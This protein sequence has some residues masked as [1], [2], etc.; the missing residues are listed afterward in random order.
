MVPGEPDGWRVVAELKRDALGRVERVVHAD[1]RVGV[2]RVACGGSLPGSRLVARVLLRRERRAL[3]ALAGLPQVPTLLAHGRGW[4]VR[5][6]F[7][8]EPLHR[9][10]ALPRDFFAHLGDLVARLHARGVAHNDLHKEPNVL[11]LA[12]G[13]PALVDFQL[14]SVHRPGSRGLRTRSAEDRRHVH[15]HAT[16]YERQ[17]M[18]AAAEEVERSFAARVWARGWKPFYNTLTRRWLRRPDAEG[19]RPKQGPWPRWQAPLGP[20]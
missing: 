6:W 20:C 7:D 10:L 15:K 1:G 17:G 8:G 18:R 14:A 19:R 12:D 2:R 4:L 13:R 9:A 16:R 3:A 5:S 11:V